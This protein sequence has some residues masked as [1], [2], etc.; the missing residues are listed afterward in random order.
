MHAQA[1]DVH[2]LMV[3]RG[4]LDDICQLTAALII[5]HQAPLLVRVL[6][7]IVDDRVR[8]L[9]RAVPPGLHF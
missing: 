9:S 2:I 4:H 7:S 5:N 3:E 6:T 1:A 8:C